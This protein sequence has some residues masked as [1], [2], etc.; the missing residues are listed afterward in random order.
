MTY[1][2]TVL[3]EL[4]SA[5][6]IES[7]QLFK[8]TEAVFNLHDDELPEKEKAQEIFDAAEA[9]QKLAAAKKAANPKPKT[10][11]DFRTLLGVLQAQSWF[12]PAQRRKLVGWLSEA[13]VDPKAAKAEKAAKASDDGAQKQ[14]EAVVAAMKVLKAAVEGPAKAE[15]PKDA[16]KKKTKAAAKKEKETSETASEEKEKPAKKPRKSRKGAGKKK[17]GEKEGEEKASTEEGEKKAEEKPA[18]KV[19]ESAE[20][21]AAVPAG[22]VG[23]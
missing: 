10:Y 20:V 3:G 19:V 6:E 4:K 21:P 16:K 5:T 22:A 13:C 9:L 18:A 17:E 7:Q 1:L 8:F 15:E 12:S 23:A 11:G 2:D 14:L